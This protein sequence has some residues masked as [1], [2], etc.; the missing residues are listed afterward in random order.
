MADNDKIT[1][2][3]NRIYALDEKVYKAT[4]SNLG[5]VYQGNK[6]KCINDLRDLLK[7]SADSS[8][9]RSELALISNMAR[10]TKKNPQLHKEIMH[11][12]G[13]I[14][15]EAMAMQEAREGNDIIDP[16][17]AELN[18]SNLANRFGKDDNLIICIG[19]SYG[20]AGTDIGF[21]LADKLRIS[22]YD[23]SI[24]NEIL[25]RNEEHEETDRALFQNKTA[26]TPAQWWRDFKKYHGLSRSDVQFFNT[27]KKLI[28]LAK[29][30]PYV[31]M[32]RYAFPL[33][34][35]LI[36]VV[37]PILRRPYTMHIWKEFLLYAV[38][39]LFNSFFLPINLSHILRPPVL[40]KLILVKLSLLNLSLLK[41][42]YPITF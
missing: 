15:D 39:K 14:F 40:I 27:S 35:S 7:S 29:Q 3:A 41:L 26:R 30:E 28:D 23:V 31:I 34:N 16:E 4:G 19:R 20:C 25:Q 33:I 2:L 37:F 21:K 9:L 36:R 13:E 10:T 24:M 5:R 8:V 32:G 11:E 12:Y 6:E 18:M 38:S 1:E 42:V 22:Y 17:H